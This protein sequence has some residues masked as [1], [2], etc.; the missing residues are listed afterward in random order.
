MK[1]IRS[2]LLALIMLA[3]LAAC[4]KDGLDLNPNSNSSSS[5]SGSDNSNSPDSNPSSSNDVITP[6]DGMAIGYE[7]DTLRTVFFDMK[8]ENPQTCDEF[9]GLTPDEG[10]KFLTADLTL[11]NYTDY[12][13]L[14]FDTDFEVIWDLD[15]D[16][17]WAWPECNETTDANGE[18]EY[19]VR[20]DKQLPIEYT[21]GIHKS[22]TGLLLYQVP[23]DSTDFFI[24]FYEVFAP[25][26]EGDEPEYGD[27]FFVRFSE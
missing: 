15:D 13:Q 14:M 26:E 24:A 20:S 12:S 1:R 4:G 8:I 21:L 5:P 23:A 7:G 2:L 17:A 19:S 6:E 16:D 22:Q 27:S 10:Y 25:E 18:P 11:Y 3:S 9:D